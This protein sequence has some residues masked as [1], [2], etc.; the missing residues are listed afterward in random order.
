MIDDEVCN[1]P[2]FYI[3]SLIMKGMKNCHVRLCA[4]LS[5]VFLSYVYRSGLYSFT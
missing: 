2:A 5:R 4:L 3:L 1:E